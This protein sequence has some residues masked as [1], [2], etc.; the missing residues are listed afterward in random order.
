M[1]KN[2]VINILSDYSRLDEIYRLTHDSLVDV[3]AIT[4]KRDGK[5]KTSPHLDRIPETSTVITEQNGQIVATISIT[6]DNSLG[7]PID[8]YFKEETDAIRANSSDRVGVIWRIASRKE[9]R[10]NTHLIMDTIAKGTQLMHASSCRIWLFCIVEKHVR[11]Y[12]RFFDAENVSR[13]IATVDREIE[14]PMLLMQAD[15]EK[16]WNTFNVHAR[17]RL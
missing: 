2:Y 6:A 14:I 8:N 5:V 16:A 13:K 3:G 12:R 7:L 1:E 17:D 11:F 4:P 10:R 15:V 9:C